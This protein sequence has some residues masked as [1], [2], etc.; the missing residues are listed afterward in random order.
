MKFS[1]SWLRSQGQT[2]AA[3]T[4]L[5][6]SSANTM[7]QIR[8]DEFQGVAGPAHGPIMPSPGVMA[9]SF[10]L[11]GEVSALQRSQEVARIDAL[12]GGSDSRRF[13]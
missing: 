2:S 13:A 5:V 6:A 1:E 12:A 11:H 8:I 4:V 3:C 7:S 10:E 9:A